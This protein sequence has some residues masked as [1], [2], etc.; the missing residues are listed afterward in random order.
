MMRWGV[1]IL[2]LTILIAAGVAGWMWF[3]PSPEKAVRKRLT[4]VAAAASFA[5]NE[6]AVAK[7]QN[8]QKLMSYCTADIEV[9]VDAYNQR[10]TCTGKDELM[11]AVMYARTQLFGSLT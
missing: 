2:V 8:A 1:R 6:G 10:I 7:L 4:E 5:A 9:A 3:F 11:Q